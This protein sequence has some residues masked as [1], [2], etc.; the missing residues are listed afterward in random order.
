M[1][2]NSVAASVITGTTTWISVD[3]LALKRIGED[4]SAAS[5]PAETPPPARCGSAARRGCS[6]SGRGGTAAPA[7]GPISRLPAI[8]SSPIISG[9]RA[10]PSTFNSVG[11]VVALNLRSPRLKREG[12]ARS[13]SPGWDLAE[14]IA[15]REVSPEVPVEL[16]SDVIASGATTRNKDGLAHPPEQGTLRPTQLQ[17]A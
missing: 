9:L 8:D 1:L 14:G 5:E 12:T 4:A 3:A 17:V 10:P 11:I 16:T 7:T 2:S 6:N 15:P 13:G